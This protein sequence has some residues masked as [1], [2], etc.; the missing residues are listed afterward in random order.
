MV[1]TNPTS[2][3][4]RKPHRSK[5]V[6]FTNETRQEH[7]SIDQ[8]S[9]RFVEHGWLV[10]SLG[11]DLGEDVLV[12]IY[13]HGSFTGL[14]FL[15]QCK[16]TA[17]SGKLFPK[18]DKSRLR[19][20]LDVHDLLHWEVAAQ[21]IVV[22]VWDVSKRTGWWETVP[23]IIAD[24][25]K[26]NGGWRGKQSITASFPSKNTT[27]APALG[28]LRH[29]VADHS[30]PVVAKGKPMLI[31][32]TFRFPKTPEGQEKLAEFRR[33]LD[34]GT[35]V[36][37]DGRFISAFRMPSWYERIYGQIKPDSVAI[38]PAAPEVALN[39]RLEVESPRGVDGIPLR[40]K[41]VRSGRIEH[42]LSNEDD[43]TPI[44]LKIVIS[45]VG[46]DDA[47][48]QA[49][50]TN[51]LPHPSI[52]HTRD[53]ARFL[54]RLRRASKVRVILPDTGTVLFQTGGW[55]ATGQSEEELRWW[56]RIADMLCVIQSRIHQYGTLS[57]ANADLSRDDVEA[58][59]KMYEICRSGRV[60]VRGEL[61]FNWS[62]TPTSRSQME[63]AIAS[64]RKGTG[65]GFEVRFSG[66]KAKV[67][68][69]EVPIATMVMRFRDPT[70]VFE[71]VE[72]ALEQNVESVDIV[73]PDLPVTEEYPDF[74]PT[75]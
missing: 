70:P 34:T 33:A 23:K 31:R 6:R 2:S 25:D 17:D 1:T 56:E 15:L 27:E 13:D 54:L 43:D 49:G 26:T 53:A 72:R 39:V 61:K 36:T 60:N 30:L 24:L 9:D 57:L 10:N 14:T 58:I 73:C 28:R 52:Y 75:G 69:V 3:T 4:H 62:L 38:S 7:R 16:S 46:D 45:Q 55:K 11:R 29:I 74:L 37:L 21:L 68:N 40:L 59:G 5:G 35:P 67:L 48:V 42:E 66:G 51:T 64:W 44:H 41:L 50:L 8:L 47:K 19:Y 20:R 32:P 63:A 65:S 18:R 12:N 22:M 71:Q